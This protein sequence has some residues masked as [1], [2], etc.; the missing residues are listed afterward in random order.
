MCVGKCVHA[1]QSSGYNCW[2]MP[3]PFCVT[4]ISSCGVHAGQASSV[5]RLEASAAAAEGCDTMHQLAK[6]QG[7]HLRR[8]CL[9]PGCVTSSP[10]LRST[11]APLASHQ[12]AACG[13]TPLSLARP[14]FGI[15]VRICLRHTPRST[16]TDIVDEHRAA[17]AFVGTKRDRASSVHQATAAQRD[18]GRTPPQHVHRILNQRRA[19]RRPAPLRR[20]QTPAAGPRR[21]AARPAHMRRARPPA[22]ARACAPAGGP[23]AA[24]AGVSPAPQAREPGRRPLGPKQPANALGGHPHPTAREWGVL[25]CAATRAGHARMRAC[26]TGEAPHS[27]RPVSL[28][29]APARRP[30][31]RP[32][33]VTPNAWPPPRGGARSSKA[34]RA[35]HEV[36]RHARRADVEPQQRGRVARARRVARLAP[37][38]WPNGHCCS[39][40]R[41]GVTTVRAPGVSQQARRLRAYPLHCTPLQQRGAASGTPDTVRPLQAQGKARQPRHESTHGQ[42]TLSACCTAGSRSA[43]GGRPR[44]SAASCRGSSAAYSSPYA[45]NSALHSLSCAAAGSADDVWVT[46]RLNITCH[47]NAV[48]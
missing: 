5:T 12:S 16:R 28:R 11:S 23:A 39:G 17:Q 35:H 19:P 7:S 31:H 37:A 13:C 2:P 27:T 40:S 26:M 10:V 34:S 46:C 36:G 4:C 21:R 18:P 22:S 41:A 32:R 42:R 9:L 38:R 8:G 47:L 44:S 33:T 1:E 15:T 30:R 29:Q 45:A 48:T 3:H 43:A 20:P 14:F 6:D 25:P 24:R